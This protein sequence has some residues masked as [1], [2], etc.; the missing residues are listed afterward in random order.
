M[1]VAASLAQVIQVK[2]ASQNE[3]PPRHQPLIM[4]QRAVLILPSP[5]QPTSRS[6]IDILK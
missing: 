2:P 3:E 1:L 4:P 6:D 5:S